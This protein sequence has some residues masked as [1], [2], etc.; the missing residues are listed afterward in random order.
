MSDKSGENP[1]MRGAARGIIFWTVGCIRIISEIP[2]KSGKIRKSEQEGEQFYGGRTHPEKAQRSGKSA[3]ERNRKG[4][5]FGGWTYPDKV[6]KNPQLRGHAVGRI[7]KSWKKSENSE[8]RGAGRRKKC[9]G[10]SHPEKLEK[11][12]KSG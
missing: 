6:E 8:I 5:N 12:G 7:R 2:D 4:T 1:E 3:N 11:V 9:G 10:R